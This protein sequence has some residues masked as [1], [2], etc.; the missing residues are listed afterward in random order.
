MYSQEHFKPIIRSK[1]LKLANSKKELVAY[2]NE[3]LEHPEIFTKQ[4]NT[5]LEEII[6][7][8]DGTSTDRVVS[9]IKEVIQEIN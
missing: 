6:T 3:A 2:V 9:V 4:C 7:F 8:R 1:G 5:I